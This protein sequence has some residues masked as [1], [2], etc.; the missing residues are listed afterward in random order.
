LYQF[1]D[2]LDINSKRFTISSVIA[3]VACSAMGPINEYLTELRHRDEERKLQAIVNRMREDVSRRKETMAKVV[4]CPINLAAFAA[5][6]PVE[7]SPIGTRAQAQSAGPQPDS[8][9]AEGYALIDD[10]FHKA[11]AMPDDIVEFLELRRGIH[12]CVLFVCMIFWSYVFSLPLWIDAECHGG[13]PGLHRALIVV[14]CV[15]LLCLELWLLGKSRRGVEYLDLH[16]KQVAFHAVLASMSRYDVFSDVVFVL[17]SRDCGYNYWPIGTACLIV[18][19]G[20]MQ[21]LPGLLLMT[22]R[23]QWAYAFK[24]NDFNMLLAAMKHV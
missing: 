17:V 4:D 15:V 12:V 3:G 16:K 18:G 23:R 6:E 13:L 22:C 8:S 11:L 24:F 1:W 7:A 5:G 14:L 9:S 19:V 20:L 10:G 21:G 2:E